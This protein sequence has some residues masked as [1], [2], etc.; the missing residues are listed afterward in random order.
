MHPHCHTAHTMVVC[1]G[2]FIWEGPDLRVFSGEWGGCQDA[3]PRRLLSLC[4]TCVLLFEY[5][6]HVSENFQLKSVT[7]YY[8]LT[9]WQ[10]GGCWDQSV[11]LPLYPH[12]AQYVLEL[13]FLNSERCSDAPAVF[14]LYCTMFAQF[15]LGFLDTSQS[16]WLFQSSLM[17]PSLAITLVLP[18]IHSAVTSIFI[19]LAEVCDVEHF[20]QPCTCAYPILSLS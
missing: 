19:Q 12:L 15:V 11:N 20:Q 8:I 10:S 3:M 13:L 18:C 5:K 16:R 14:C 4:S 6:R 17:H 7:H 2:A 1:A 9:K